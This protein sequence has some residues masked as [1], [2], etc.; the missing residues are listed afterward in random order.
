M[1][2]TKVIAIFD[3]GKTNKKLLLFD[4]QYKLVHEVSKQFEE[5]VDEDG[6]PCE[7]VHALTQWIKDSFDAI[8]NDANFHVRAINFS[9][10]GASFVYLDSDLNVCL[11]LYNYLKPYSPG[12]QQQFYDTYGGERLVAKQTASPVLGNLNSGMQL[13]RLKYEKPEAFAAIK[14]ALH[15]PQ[16]LSFILSAKLNSDITSI[17]CHTNL[18]NFQNNK[19]H[20]WV[21]LENILPKLPPILGCEAIAGYANERIPVG[22]GLHDSSSALIPYFAAFQEP[23]VLLSTGTWCISMNPFNHTPLSDDELQQDCLCYLSYKINPVKASRLFAGYEHELQ[24]KRLS[25]HFNKP[26]NYFATVLYNV[27][28]LNNLQL[29]NPAKVN[30]SSGAMVHN[31]DFAERDLNTFAS[32]EKAYHQLIA[33]I[34]MQQIK[35]TRLVLTGSPV[36]R[37]FVDGGFSKNSIYMHLL[38][39]AFTGIEVY[40]A[41]VAQASALGAALVMHQHWNSKPLPAD[42]IELKLYKGL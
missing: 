21:E 19:Y 16:Y 24:T 25:E 8:T 14:H 28:I 40:A 41:T 9:A 17:G 22:V 35:S 18:W 4:E 39:E 2:K 23:F 38:A 11:P 15:L 5:T 34:I 36:K 1:K 10:Y 42:I 7:D 6:F 37:I 33:N 27:E 3:V 30:A 32:Y 26:L 31:S 20:K 13:Y 12:L 29:S